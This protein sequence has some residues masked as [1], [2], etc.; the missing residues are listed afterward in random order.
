VAVLL[1]LRLRLLQLLV[2]LLVRHVLVLAERVRRQRSQLADLLRALLDLGLERQL[3]A[4][5]ANNRPIKVF[6]REK[7]NKNSQV[8]SYNYLYLCLSIHM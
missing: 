7:L 5:K 6:F 8:S 2:E 3:K 4:I 1:Q